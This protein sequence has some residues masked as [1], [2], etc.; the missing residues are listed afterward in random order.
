MHAWRHQPR[1]MKLQCLTSPLPALRICIDLGPH[2]ARWS[3]L[4]IILRSTI[5]R[6]LIKALFTSHYVCCACYWMSQ[7]ILV[8]RQAS[9]VFLLLFTSGTST[10]VSVVST[11]GRTIQTK[12][13]LVITKHEKKVK[14]MLMFQGLPAAVCFWKPAGSWMYM[15]RKGAATSLQPC[16][17]SHSSSLLRI[18]IRTSVYMPHVPKLHTRVKCTSYI[19]VQN[20]LVSPLQ[21]FSAVHLKQT[22]TIGLPAL[23]ATPFSWK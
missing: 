7:F 23:L 2:L 17:S 13:D 21:Q 4:L 6:K 8:S 15:A 5:R 20:N 19:S 11:C 1:Q 14:P 9:I 3:T 18:T 10:F 22:F 12:G 16:L